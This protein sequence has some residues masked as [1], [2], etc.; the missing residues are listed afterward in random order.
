MPTYVLLLRNDASGATQMLFNLVS[1]YAEYE[2]SVQRFSGEL[3]ALYPVVGRFDA[4]SIV[5]FQDPGACL[6]FVL[7]SEG[8]GQYAEQL[9]VLELDDLH[10]AEAVHLA[11][12]RAVAADESSARAAARKEQ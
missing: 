1:G 11:A 6:A 10:Q 12:L 4:I 3:V 2:K 9:Q 7:A 5:R 8:D